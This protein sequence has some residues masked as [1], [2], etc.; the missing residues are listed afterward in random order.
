MRANRGS[1]TKPEL[2]IRSVLHRRGLRFRKNVRVDLG[3]GQRVRPDIVF[4][5]L[6]LAIFIDGCFWHGCQE[7]RSL[8]ASNVAFWHKKISGT[9]RRD[10]LHV[11][12]LRQSGWT[13]VR[14][15]EHE[16]PEQ[17]A[18]RIVELVEAL[19]ASEVG[20]RGNPQG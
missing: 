8:P 15:W 16:P 9:I 7:H 18:G 3:P 12:W 1:D 19:R 11:R 20:H 2:A 14:I 10:K 4:P 13:A 17:A 6:R 5:R